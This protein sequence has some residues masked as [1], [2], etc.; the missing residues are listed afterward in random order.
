MLLA[1]LAATSTAVRDTSAR[2]AK[3]ALIA[4][5]LADA[6][7]DEIEA[8]VAYLSGDLRQRRT[9]L[10]RVTARS[11]RSRGR[12]LGPGWRGGR[13]VEGISVLGGAGS[14]TERDGGCSRNSL[15]ASRGGG[16]LR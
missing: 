2:S 3:I 9:R 8:T 4:A 14:Q 5:C 1:R 7:P 6:E 10:G 11:T 15:A 12:S 16:R 13:D